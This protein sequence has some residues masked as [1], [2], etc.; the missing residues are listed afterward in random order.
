MTPAYPLGR[1]RRNCGCCH[2]CGTELRFVLDGEEYCD[3][4]CHQHQT[5]HRTKFSE[6][7]I[8]YILHISSGMNCQ[9][10]IEKR[11]IFLGGSK[12]V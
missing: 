8:R 9:V 7:S 6:C 2:E 10:R 11:H 4:C 5:H 12:K 1:P 3:G